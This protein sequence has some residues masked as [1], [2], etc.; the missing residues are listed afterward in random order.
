MGEVATFFFGKGP[1]TPSVGG[2][3]RVAGADSKNQAQ[4]AAERRRRMYAGIGR[5][6]TILTGQSG[7]GSLGD[8]NQA[9][10]ELLGI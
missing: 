4:K 10:K 2:P 5:S 8:S 7:L 6:S 3:P 1:T 9:P